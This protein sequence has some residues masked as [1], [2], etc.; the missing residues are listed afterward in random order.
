MLLGFFT[1]E[2]MWRNHERITYCNS[3]DPEN[4]GVVPLIRHQFT[5]RVR[6]QD[7]KFSGGA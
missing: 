2:R 6:L 7:D 3:M 1:K 5:Q 4:C